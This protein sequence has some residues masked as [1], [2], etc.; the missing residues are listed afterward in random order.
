MI[1]TRGQ[2]WSANQLPRLFHS[3]PVQ[4][5]L[6]SLSRLTLEVSVKTSDMWQSNN[7]RLMSALTHTQSCVKLIFSGCGFRS[8][9]EVLST[10]K[11]SQKNIE[12]FP[13]TVLPR[14]LPTI[15]PAHTRTGP[16]S[17]WGSDGTI[18]VQ[19]SLRGTGHTVRTQETY[20]SRGRIEVCIM[21]IID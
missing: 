9:S 21:R 4:P 10:E 6:L 8:A 19:K 20:D 3:P 16:R 2:A 18:W 13:L 14:V 7:L 1:T 17:F 15:L 12:T 11:K 5:T